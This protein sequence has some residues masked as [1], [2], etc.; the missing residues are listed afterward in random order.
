MDAWSQKVEMTAYCCHV[1]PQTI[2]AALEGRWEQGEHGEV[3]S[4]TGSVA[5]VECDCEVV[6]CGRGRRYRC[7]RY[8]DLLPF[9]LR[10]ADRYCS[11][12]V[13]FATS[14]LQGD[15]GCSVE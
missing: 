13:N 1:D 9:C 7:Q 12:G 14:T 2:C 5:S 4:L 6:R 11:R 3:D 15:G 8:C 10:S